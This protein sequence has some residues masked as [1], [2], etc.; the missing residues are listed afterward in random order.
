MTDKERHEVQVE[1]V[2]KI[3]KFLCQGCNQGLPLKKGW[4]MDMKGR[5]TLV[6]NFCNAVRIRALFDEV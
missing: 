5:D 4:H 3:S 1:C 6:N 2:E